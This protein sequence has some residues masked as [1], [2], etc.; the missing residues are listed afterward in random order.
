MNLRPTEGQGTC[1]PLRFRPG[2]EHAHRDQSTGQ[3]NRNAKKE[4]PMTGE[5][6]ETDKTR[7]PGK[8]KIKNPN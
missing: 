7:A 1:L 5:G 3:E 4:L 2:G 8:S 6:T